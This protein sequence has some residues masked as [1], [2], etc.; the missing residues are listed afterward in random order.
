MLPD[1]TGDGD[2]PPGV[3]VA[4]WQEFESRFGG[5]SPRRLWLSSRLRALVELA[6]TTGKLRRVFVWGSF[7]TAKPAP[8]DPTSS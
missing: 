6:A 7:V 4:S 2:L 8:R 3:H 1:L 5:P